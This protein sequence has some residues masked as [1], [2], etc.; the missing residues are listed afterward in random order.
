LVIP[1]SF[2]NAISFF[3]PGRPREERWY[4]LHRKWTGS[5]I[6]LARDLDFAGARFF[7]GLPAVFVSALHEAKAW[8]MR[9]LD[10]QIR[11]HD[12]SPYRVRCPNVRQNLF[13]NQ[14]QTFGL[15]KLVRIDRL[16]KSVLGVTETAER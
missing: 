2:V 16:S 9:T 8:D 7:T 5:V 11:R 6:A 15:R 10:R 1:I 13:N 12:G 3:K 4:G 14:Y